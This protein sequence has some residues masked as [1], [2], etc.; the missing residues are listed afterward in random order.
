MKRAFLVI[1]TFVFAIATNAAETVQLIAPRAGQVLE[2]G[3]ETT[4][5]WSA[6]S[7][8][9]HAEEWE[10]FL[11]VDG[12]RYYAV[13]ITPHL[14]V[15]I[16]SFRWRVPNVAASKARI[17]I[18][19]GDER[20]EQIIRLPQSFMI[21]PQATPLEFAALQIASTEA[22]SEPALP[23]TPPVVE[24]VAGDRSGGHLVRQRNRSG[25]SLQAVRPIGDDRGIAAAHG[26]DQASLHPPRRA[27]RR[28][29]RHNPDLLPAGLP[30]ATRPL[31][32]LITRLNI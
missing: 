24:W 19:V 6:A 18:R 8:P 31:L 10:A 26:Q 2:G 28:P 30:G 14:D 23:G 29:L 12:G 27:V 1:A 5:V 16:R 11:S 9:D 15:Q 17:L 7:L 20:D 4:L 25:E 22:S 21:V 32:L 3:R 13:R